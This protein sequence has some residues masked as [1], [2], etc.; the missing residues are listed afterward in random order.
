MK[1]NLSIF[2]VALLFAGSL[3]STG[4][5]G[6][7]PAAEIEKL[8]PAS[9]GENQDKPADAK[10]PAPEKAAEKPPEQPVAGIEIIGLKNLNPQAILSKMQ[11][12]K[13]DAYSQKLLEDD[14]KRLSESGFFS[15]INWSTEPAK[16]G[17]KIILTVEE[18]EHIQTIN[19]EGFKAFSYREVEQNIK[20]KV[21]GPLDRAALKYDM[22]VI[23]EKYLDKGYHFV[24][25]NNRI[26]EG[27]K[28]KIVTYIVR[29]GPRVT[30]DEI[31]FNGDKAF[32]P[33]K[34]VLIFNKH[35]LLALMNTQTNGWLT[36]SPYREKELY[37]DLERIKTFYRNDGW[38]DVDVFVEDVRFNEP[39]SRVNITIHIDEGRCY[40]IRKL[41]VTGNTVV[42][43]ADIAGKLKVKEKDSYQVKT[44]AGD[45]RTI[46]NIY[47]KS[48]YIDCN[49][50]VRTHFIPASGE[51]DLTYA[52]VEGTASYLEKIKISGNAKTRD[53]VIRREMVIHP[54]DLMDHGAIQTSLDHI[55]STRYFQGLNFDIEPGSKPDTKNLH[56]MIDEGQTGM[57]RLGGG[58]SSNY[59]FG[60]ILEYQQS[61]FDLSR[62]PRSFEDFFSSKAFAGGG[63]SLRLFWQPGIE[64]SQTGINFV[65]PYLM[66]KPIELSVRYSSFERSWLEYDEDRTGGSFTLAYRLAKN[67]KIGAGPRVERIGISNLESTAPTSIVEM[68]G[69][70]YLR[71][72]S[73]F[74]EEDRRDSWLMPSRG[75][76]W[77]VTG[78]SA[79]G[80]LGGDFDFIRSNVKVS[81][82]KTLYYLTDNKKIIFNFNTKLARIKE[83][84]DS[85]EVPSFERL[86]AGGFDSVRGFDFRSISPKEDGVPVG[87]KVLAVVN[88]EITYPLYSEEIA[89][90]R[91]MDIIKFVL[92]YDLG[93]VTDTISRMTWDTTRSSAGFG[94]RFMLGMIP[95]SLSAAY[96]IK[97]EPDD[98]T[99]RLQL[100]IGMGF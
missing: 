71:T 36:S 11:S 51:V 91:P 54:G 13:G 73:L 96:P 89:A 59:G 82:Y 28:G 6:D 85:V 83:F 93:N 62:T 76:L 90:G 72:T 40:V 8:K 77:R 5:C 86:Y 7:P 24:E 64:T 27:A 67:W 1:N 52:L 32:P 45:L 100:D 41:A 44:I 79:G 43:T 74:I 88:N 31:T 46:K 37:L 61:N 4:W 17:I 35:P 56:L 80:G 3:V 29:E 84:G 66:N 60:G 22:N 38:L 58:Y 47:G 57:V 55:A 78:E 99:Q 12:R 92:F 26:D 23:K 53:K 33:Y 18:T 42:P 98:D 94:L 10:E 15:K 39:R 97:Q 50:D 48:G 49:I 25:V 81:A 19:Y 65:E 75:Y 87:G 30:V 9:S 69:R 63:Q 70:N 95:V 68:A 2:L 34:V 21:D 16:D 14:V 20:L